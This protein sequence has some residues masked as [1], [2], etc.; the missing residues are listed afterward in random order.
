MQVGKMEDK[1]DLRQRILFYE[2]EFDLVL[3][4]ERFDESLV[5]MKDLLC[6]DIE[7]IM[8]LKVRK[9]VQKYLH[10]DHEPI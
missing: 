6:W 7:D 4:A 5:V 8:Y 2:S 9:Q 3:L 10:Q 1:S